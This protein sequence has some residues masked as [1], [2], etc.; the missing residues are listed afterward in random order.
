MVILM[1]SLFLSVEAP[2]SEDAFYCDG[3]PIP[4]T[5]S[6]GALMEESLAHR[7]AIR[8]SRGFTDWYHQV[9]GL[10]NI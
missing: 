2:V 1:F 4:S 6:L 8:E 7:R 3:R 5:A 10:I 9:S